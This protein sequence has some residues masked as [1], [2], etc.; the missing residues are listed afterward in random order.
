VIQTSVFPQLAVGPT[1]ELRQPQSEVKTHKEVIQ[2]S[3]QGFVQSNTHKI[4]KK[5]IVHGNKKK[6]SK[7]TAVVHIYQCNSDGKNCASV[8]PL[9]FLE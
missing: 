9:I 5:L 7:N 8:H 2:V 6:P 1:S 4:D 3:S